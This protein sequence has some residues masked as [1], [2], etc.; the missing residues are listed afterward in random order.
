MWLVIQ[1]MLNLSFGTNVFKPYEYLPWISIIN[2]LIFYCKPHNGS[3][4][5]PSYPLLYCHIDSFLCPSPWLGLQPWRDFTKWAS[6][7]SCW[8]D[9]V[10]ETV[11]SLRSAH[12][13]DPWEGC[14]IPTK[15]WGAEN[16]RPGLQTRKGVFLSSPSVRFYP[17][18]VLSVGEICSQ[19]INGESVILFP[20]PFMTLFVFLWMN[21]SN[22]FQHFC[23]S[24][25]C[26]V[27]EAFCFQVSIA[28]DLLWFPNKEWKV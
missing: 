25:I 28:C 20:S 4:W 15:G 26:P 13:Q 23:S 19:I 9:R 8:Q 12:P 11:S 22:H 3:P 5:S 1:W 17:G 27:S 16:R 7:F 6:S 24:S 21:S 2:Y 14:R 10:L 18:Q